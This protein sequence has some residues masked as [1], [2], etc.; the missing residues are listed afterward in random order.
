MNTYIQTA[1]RAAGAAIVRECGDECVS[2]AIDVTSVTVTSGRV[3]NEGAL[4]R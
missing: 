1:I 2:R 3:S 4:G